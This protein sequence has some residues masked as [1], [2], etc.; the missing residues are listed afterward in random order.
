MTIDTYMLYL[1]AV[2]VFFATPPD[3][4]QLL[5][6]SN[7]MRHGLQRSLWTLFG[8]LSANTLQMTAAAFGLAAVIAT[9]ATAFTVIKWLGVAYLAWIGLQMMLSLPD[10]RDTEQTS[11]VSAN[12]ARAGF[13]WRQGFFTS[14]ANPFAVVFFAALFPQFITPGAPVLPQLMVLGLTYLVVDGVILLLWGWLGQSAA[15]M[16]RGVWITRTCG[17]LMMGAAAL[18]AGKDIS[19]QR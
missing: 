14:L 17:A 3:T 16:L 6:I 10:G 19:P 15:G 13:L 7:S 4:S 1:G 5:I 9:S 2:A 8:D 12:Q 11:T 18:L